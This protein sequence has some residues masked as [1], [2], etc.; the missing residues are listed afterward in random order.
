MKS[1]G[2]CSRFLCLMA[3]FASLFAQIDRGSIVGRV[4]DTS[5]AS[6]GGATVQVTRLSTNQVFTT[7]STESGDYTLV[8]LYPDFYE[9]KASNSG[10]KTNVRS[11][12]K[13][14]IGQ[15]VRVDFSLGV[16][17]VAETVSVTAEA[18]VLK[19]ESPELGQVIE[20]KTVVSLPVRSRDFLSFVSMVPG[21]APQRGTVGGGGLD[22]GGY[23]VSGQRKSDNVLYIDGGMM[24]QGNGA[25]TFFP[26][27]DALQEVEV[28]TGLYGAE[29]GVKPGGQISTV[30]KSGTN[31]PH[32]TLFEFHRNNI[33][34]AR[35]FFDPSALPTFRNNLFGGMF[36]G[37]VYIP[38]VVDGRNRLWFLFAASA[39]RR[40]QFQSLTGQVPGADERQGRFSGP[41]TDP[42]TGAPFPNNTIP[43]SRFHPTS[44]KLLEFY[45]A[46]NTSGRGFNYL[47]P[48][49]TNNRN[50][51]QYIAK[52]DWG[53][54]ANDRWAGSFLVDSTPGVMNSVIDTFSVVSP[55][56]TWIA[57]LRNTRTFGSAVVNDA[58]VYF[59]RRSYNPTFVQRP[60]FG[61]SLGIPELTLTFVDQSGVP[62]TAINGY[63]S[64]GDQSLSGD[65][66]I[67]QWEFRESIS[68]NKGAHSVKAGYNYRRQY[69]LEALLG[70]SSFVFNPR[71][72]GSS[73]GDFL[74]GY[75]NI[76]TQGTEILRSNTHQ[77]GH[78]M[79]IQD[80][81]KATS[82]L[83]LTL[84]LRYELRQ[85][86]LDKRGFATSFNWQTGQLDPPLQNLTLQ[87]WETGRFIPNV[88]LIEF[89]KNAFLPRIGLAY[90]VTD[91]FTIRAGYGAYGSE[92]IYAVPESFGG[93]P[94]PNA[95]TKQFTSNPTTPNLTMSDPFGTSAGPVIP[96]AAGG[97]GKW[98]NAITQQWGLNLQYGIGSRTVVEVGYQGSNGVHEPNIVAFNDATPGPGA[99]QSRR[100][101]PNYQNVTM[102]LPNGNNNTQALLTRLEHRPGP[103]GLT[104]SLAYTWLKAIDTVGGRL[105]I[106]GD[107]SARSRNLP[108]ALN[109]GLGEGNMP[110]RLA[111]T[112]GYD[113]PFGKGKPYLTEGI[114]SKIL[115]GWSV[116]G[117][118]A[119]QRG[120]WVTPVMSFDRND[121]GST[122]SF[123]PDVL[124]NPNLEASQRSTLRW[125]DTAAF[126]DPAL[127]SYG[128]AGRA[129]IQAAGIVNFD[130]ALL[131]SFNF[132]EAV[133]LEFRAEAF[134]TTNHTNFGVP[135]L[136]F[137]TPTFGVVGSA[138]ES[139]N[140]QLAVKLYF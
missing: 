91:R 116:F 38:K 122:A 104:L 46:P 105:G 66:N 60:G 140:L 102:T 78:Y 128:N 68:F 133:R 22:Q 139:R 92:P 54:T 36:S 99:R 130:A 136:A 39:E 82:R 113:L 85:P 98:P 10:F 73:L 69:G 8:N 93:N 43:S 132:T 44:L 134:N 19:T 131:R 1:F 65:V 35:N 37:P 64:I 58:G 14:E 24:S 75:P 9:I 6:I 106:V 83:T 119:Y 21:A 137:G 30:T 33:F 86:W 96:N 129:I 32:G 34:N 40:N 48:N 123:R 53:R 57:N 3:P 117:L 13:L 23:N 62:T 109:R 31:T 63:T 84:G 17:D 26:N 18:P 94:R 51:Y 4:Q 124:H 77:D 107:P 135:G 81:W 25:S 103:E 2:R 45:P 28:K 138:L 97:E 11:N 67:G 118:F 87:P 79:F 71:Y 111:I 95:T 15:S 125:F 114:G 121:V 50:T 76:T 59:F 16:G 74:L 42:S 126:R 20:N 80:S 29:F 56:K 89:E 108:I 52:I 61:A 55:L 41:I 88:P 110:G 70:R 127:Y 120:P 12:V 27:L 5:G 72:T 115:G 100:P 90:R 47:N 101:Y 7:E 49:A 112:T